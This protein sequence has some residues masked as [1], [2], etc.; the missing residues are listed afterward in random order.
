MKKLKVWIKDRCWKHP[1]S[2]MKS[3]CFVIILIKD[4]RHTEDARKRNLKHNVD[5]IVL[6]HRFVVFFAKHNF[7][8]YSN[9]SRMQNFNKITKLFYNRKLYKANSKHYISN[10]IFVYHMSIHVHSI[11]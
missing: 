6:C 2:Q 11:R 10:Q 4:S 8:T 7:R 1:D 5:N 3:S 9:N